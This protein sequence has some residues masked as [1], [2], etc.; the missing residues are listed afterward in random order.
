MTNKDINFFKK[1][2]YLIVT[3][4]N[5]LK[6]KK[7]IYFDL[8][9]IV[10]K[11]LSLNNIDNFKGNSF[12][13]LI[14]YAFKF[15]KK[16]SIFSSCYDL[17]PGVL[18]VNKLANEKIFIDISKKLGLA[19]PIIGSLPQI[20]IDRP[21]DKKR[22]TQLHQDIWYSFLSNNSLTF[23]FSIGKLNKKTGPLIIYP[24][25]HKL[26]IQKFKDNKKGTFSADIDI[27]RFNSYEALLKDDQLIVFNQYLLHESGNNISKLPRISAQIRF[28][29]IT[30]L[31]QP[32]SS[33]RSITSNFVINEQ[34][35]YKL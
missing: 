28:N 1:Y 20:R 7:N 9:I 15:D 32:F 19:N 23:W 3:N 25:S 8:K 24:E 31:N 21:N 5:I 34:K 26:G 27:K 17:L 6:L 12:D 22:K 18:S 2:G 29:D 14:K 10:N 33:F 16:Y 4:K 30:T 35:K 13:N 11:I